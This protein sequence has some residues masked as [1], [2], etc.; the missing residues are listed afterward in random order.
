MRRARVLSGKTPDGE[1]TLEEYQQ[2]YQKYMLARAANIQATRAA[3]NKQRVVEPKGKKKSV[4]NYSAEKVAE[5]ASSSGEPAMSLDNIQPGRLDLI[6]D[7]FT[8]VPRKDPNRP[9]CIV[10]VNVPFRARPRQ[11]RLPSPPRIPRRK[12]GC[13]RVYN[14]PLPWDEVELPSGRVVS[15]HRV[16]YMNKPGGEWPL[17]GGIKYYLCKNDSDTEVTESCYPAVNDMIRKGESETDPDTPAMKTMEDILREEKRGSMTAEEHA[18]SLT[19]IR[20][21]LAIHAIWVDEDGEA[22]GEADQVAGVEKPLHERLGGLKPN[23]DC[24]DP[25]FRM[26]CTGGG[27]ADFSPDARPLDEGKGVE[28]VEKEDQGQVATEA[29]SLVSPQEEK[30]DEDGRDDATSGQEPLVI[31]LSDTSSDGSGLLQELGGR[32]PDVMEEVEKELEI[33]RKVKEEQ[34][35]LSVGV[36]VGSAE[37]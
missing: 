23:Q 33:R 18:E 34:N 6:S 20:E 22:A 12:C 2:A 1:T 24:T 16:N 8:K 36:S 19:A 37:Q 32:F 28:A 10:E 35:V 11:A 4:G 31:V 15:S 14:N 5:P 13:K 3:V 21:L 25:E 7:R 17:A 29:V 26:H 9:P 27:G 30:A